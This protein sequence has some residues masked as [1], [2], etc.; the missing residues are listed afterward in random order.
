MTRNQINSIFSEYVGD[1]AED[2][3]SISISN[4]NEFICAT[5]VIAE[6]ENGN[7]SVRWDPQHR[8]KAVATIKCEFLDDGRT[9]S[10]SGDES[11]YSIIG[12]FG[13]KTDELDADH[14]R[15][16]L[17]RYSF[18]KKQASQMSIFDFM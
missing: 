9:I 3:R 13:Y 11:T 18:R 17:E 6:D 2:E 5:N 14:I 1:I 12:G 16:T 15:R 4:L 10:F 7:A 8:K